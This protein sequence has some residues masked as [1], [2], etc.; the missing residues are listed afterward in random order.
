MA[1]TF[2]TPAQVVQRMAAS[3]D[4]V[5]ATMP[6]EKVRK[7]ADTTGSG[8]GIGAALCASLIMAARKRIEKGE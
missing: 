6:I 5:V 7:L 1:N 2:L 8:L 4:E 3:A